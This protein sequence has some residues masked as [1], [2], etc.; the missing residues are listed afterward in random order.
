L[1]ISKNIKIGVDMGL[2][3][4]YLLSGNAG[5]QSDQIER[6][7]QILR[8]H[9]TYSHNSKK[10]GICMAMVC[11]WFLE[12]NDHADPVVMARRILHDNLGPHGFGMLTTSQEFYGSQTGNDFGH[13]RWG[14]D[15]RMFRSHTGG[16]LQL[17]QQWGNIGN[18][19]QLRN[20]ILAISG[21]SRMLYIRFDGSLFWG[22]CPWAHAIG[23][24]RD[25]NNIFYIFDPNY[26]IFRFPSVIQAN[27]R[28]FSEL[29]NAYSPT[30]AI[31][32]Q[33]R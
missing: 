4:K 29:W 2:L 6:G 21:L 26:G 8:H 33:I 18:D 9:P 15:D 11:Q 16:M 30:S 22:L 5:D 20:R 28:F 13:V 23:A 3:D 31:V 32:Y 19:Q 10:K 12:L 27:I 24:Y 14:I 17:N 25:N 7:V 1:N